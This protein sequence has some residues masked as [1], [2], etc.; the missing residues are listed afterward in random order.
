MSGLVNREVFFSGL[1]AKIVET[2]FESY[3]LSNG[4]RLVHQRIESPVAYCA[5]MMNTGSRDEL[6][7]ESGVAHLVEHLM[8]KETGKRK[9]HHILSRM[10][11]VGG[12]LNAYTTKED[13]CIHAAFLNTHYAR[14]LELFND[15][16][17][18]HRVTDKVLQLEKSVVIDE[19]RSTKD[20]P[21]ELI[22]DEFDELLFPNH[23]LGR[24]TLGTAHSVNKLGKTEIERFV[25]RNYHPDQ[26]V[27]SSVGN[28]SFQRLAGYAEKYFGA[29]PSKPQAPAVRTAPAAYVPFEKRTGKR[30][31][32]S[33]CIIGTTCDSADRGFR[34]AMTM[35]ANLL[36]GPGMNTRLN[37]SLRER[38]GW[39]YHV[40]A[41][42]TPYSDVGVFNVYFASDK[43]KVEKCVIQIEKELD[44]LKRNPLT[45]EQLKKLQLQVMGQWAI[46]SDM[47]DARMLSA[48]KNIL[49]FDN[50]DNLHDI[51]VQISEVNA[52]R[53]CEVANEVFRHLSFLTYH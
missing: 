53:L 29:I 49:M 50:V 20:S 27:L 38:Y 42:Y 7:N 41:S 8:F 25:A 2:P 14:S 51:W 3:T 19:I 9:A 52:E 18:N 47:N 23:P 36:G 15:I 30:N 35:L 33:H 34:I 24:N 43:S 11:N 45:R 40:E 46:A 6:E 32:Q 37:M 5:L 12:E 4:I 13:T 26:M 28:I 16:V 1:Q 17:F 31:H 22:F 39:V 10:E 44:R 48:G 21:S